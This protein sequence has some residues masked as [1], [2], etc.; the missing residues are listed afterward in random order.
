MIAGVLQGFAP[1]FTLVGFALVISGIF[2]GG[3]YAILERCWWSSR[4]SAGAL[5]S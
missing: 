1:F 3:G 5:A 2:A 4:R